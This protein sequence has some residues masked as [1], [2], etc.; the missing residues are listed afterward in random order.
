MIV[1]VMGQDCTPS[2]AKDRI[3]TGS[4]S[5]TLTAFASSLQCYNT[6]LDS[7]F[8][9]QPQITAGVSSVNSYNSNYPLDFS[10]RSYILNGSGQ[11]S[12]TV[13]V[14]QCIL[15]GVDHQLHH[16]FQE[17]FSMPGATCPQLIR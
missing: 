8:I 9:S 5:F 6:T 15:V 14:K 16:H 13:I 17:R 10:I 3:V 4:Y 2:A 12:F 7:S 1:A 11:A